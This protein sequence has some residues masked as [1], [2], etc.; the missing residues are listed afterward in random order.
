MRWRDTKVETPEKDG[1]AVLALSN[2]GAAIVWYDPSR[3]AQW[4][5]MH[6]PG[7]G[8]TVADNLREWHSWCPVGEWHRQT[9]GLI[10]PSYYGRN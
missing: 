6:L 9:N 10:N 5:V 4:V 8:V 3:G 7:R 1:N 2:Q